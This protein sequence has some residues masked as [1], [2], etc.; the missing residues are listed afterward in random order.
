VDAVTDDRHVD[1]EDVALFQFSRAGDAVAHLVVERDADGLGEAAIVQRRRR[2]SAVVDDVIVADA[3][4]LFGR[5]AGFDVWL[6]HVEDAGRQTAGD[7]HAFDLILGLRGNG[8]ARLCGCGHRATV[9]S[10]R[11]EAGL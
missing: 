4:E 10:L 8:V 6:D 2:G 7:A 3:I 9:I 11:A 1:V 5:D